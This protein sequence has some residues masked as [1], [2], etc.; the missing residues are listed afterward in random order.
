ML[1]E[2]FRLQRNR[3]LAFV[4]GLRLLISS[5]CRELMVSQRKETLDFDSSSE[6]YM[7]HQ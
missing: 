6:L 7:P 2:T 4:P 5:N 1:A 3:L